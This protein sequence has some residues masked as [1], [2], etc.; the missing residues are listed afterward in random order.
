M[1]TRAALAAALLIPTSAAAQTLW[2]DRDKVVEQLG[3]DYAEQAI[4]MGVASNGGIIELF[5]APGGAT[6]TLVLTMPN[7]MSAIMITGQ[8]W[9]SI[10]SRVIGPPS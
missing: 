5:T 7:G 8:G 4:A 1:L 10:P 9:D 6:W 3:H 2:L